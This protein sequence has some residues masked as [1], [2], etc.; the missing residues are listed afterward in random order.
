MRLLLAEDEKPLSKALT[1]I[2]ERN[3][4]SVDAV[5]D[6]EEALEY[7]DAD[8]YDGV[9]LD[10]MMPKVDGITVLKTIRNR[11]NLITVLLLTAKSEVDDKVAG[12]DAGAN[13]Y[14]ANPFHSKELLARIRA[15]TRTQTA[16]ADSKLQIGNVTLDR[17]TFELSTPAGSFRLANK[18][19]QMLELMM[20]NPSHLI[21]AERFMEKIW[22]YDS[23]AEVNVVWVYISYLRKKLRMKLIIASMISL[24]AVLL[25]IEGIAGALNYNRIVAEAD[26][27]LEILEE[28][29]GKFPDVPPP[30]KPSEK[31]KEGR[32]SSELPYESRYFSVLLDSEGEV[33]TTDTGKIARIDTSDAVEYAKKVLKSGKERGFLEGYR[34]VVVN[35]DSEVRV[36]FLDCSRNL[37]TFQNFIVT[38]VV[39][40]TAGLL[41]VLILMIFLSARIVKPFSENYEK[42]KRFITDAGH[43]LKTPLTI[44]D[45][46]AEVLEMD[47]GENEWLSDI[48]SQTRRLADLTNNLILLSR[49]EEERTKELMVDFPLSDIAEETVGTFQA[50]AKTQNKVLESNITP[51]IAM[52]GDEKAIRRLITILLDNA[53]KYAKEN[54]RISVTLEKQKKRIRLSVFN[55][56]EQISQEHMEHLFDRFYRTDRSRNSETGGYG[57]GLS[58]AAATVE[59]HRGKITATTEDEKSLLITVIFPIS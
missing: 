25:I 14:L 11:G 54:G 15:M 9:I 7:L 46:D 50:L 23:E 47:F 28:N 24:L 36:I 57:L 34:Y 39:V 45:A 29:N 8:N 58:I 33:L 1:A 48:Q 32:M 31:K 18:E 40:S 41:A 3:N 13:D 53:V 35:S 6:G 42:Q 4:Y 59:A 56:T 22:G 37:S 38:A 21:S 5:Y 10:I 19:F 51:M 43:E 30:E 44:I 27:T 12:L 16:Q 55:T 17:A 52:K 2:L 20:S 49:M 26:Q